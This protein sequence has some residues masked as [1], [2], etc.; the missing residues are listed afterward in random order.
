[1]IGKSSAKAAGLRRDLPVWAGLLAALLLGLSSWAGCS[2]NPLGCTGDPPDG[3]PDNCRRYK[4]ACL[5]STGTEIRARLLLFL[6]YQS[7]PPDTLIKG[8]WVLRDPALTDR[9]VYFFRE[10]HQGQ[11]EGYLQNGTISILLAPE[12]RDAGIGLVG[13]FDSMLYGN[14]TGRWEEITI[15]GPVL[16]GRISARPS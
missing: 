14:F 13:T 8:C 5:D 7:Q 10:H 9:A 15:A 1:M 3:C 11:V 16:L 12:F 6:S 4:C 2:E